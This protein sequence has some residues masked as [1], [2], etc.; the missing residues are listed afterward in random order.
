MLRVASGNPRNPR[1]QLLFSVDCVH[2]YEH[3]YDDVSS[4]FRLAGL[5]GLDNEPGNCE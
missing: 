5:Q 4:I 3:H 2:E 1:L